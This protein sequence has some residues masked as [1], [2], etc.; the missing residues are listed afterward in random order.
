[1]NIFKFEFKRLLKSC[2]IWS[3]VCGALITLFMSLFPTMEDMGMQ[4]IVNNKIGGMPVE[5]LKAFNINSSMDFT[6]IFNYLGYAIQYIAMASAVYGAILGV[7]SLIREESQGTIEFLYSKPINRLKIVT[8]KLCAIVAIFYVYILIIG[9]I[10]MGVC[11]MVKPEEVEVMNLIMNIKVVF[12]GILLLGLI[13]ISLG[14]LI[15]SIVKSDKGAI[16]ISIG[17]FFVSYFLGIIGKLKDSFNWLKYFSP[18]DYYAPSEILKD[19][20]EVK[21]IIIGICVIIISIIS[22]YFIYGKK[23]MNI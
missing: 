6:D 4:Q 15:S 1:M 7:N 11:Y 12:I 5:I 13:F 2:I 20:F 9:A 18:F 21:F 19:G 3:L 8:S 23:D 22:S 14:T 17:I 10:T 16:P